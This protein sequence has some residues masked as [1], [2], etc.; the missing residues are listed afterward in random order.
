LVQAE[1]KYRLTGFGAEAV[2][3][4]QEPLQL[5]GAGRL[6]QPAVRA[7]FAD[8]IRKRWANN[9]IMRVVLEENG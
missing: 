5:L 7:Q 9:Q 3:Q 4:R 1:G 6:S 8:A 2:A